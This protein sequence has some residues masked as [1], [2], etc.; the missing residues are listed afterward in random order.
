MLP[1]DIL[2][3]FPARAQP[4]ICGAR[5]DGYATYLSVT[6]RSPDRPEL[7]QSAPRFPDGVTG[8]SATQLGYLCKCT[9]GYVAASAISICWAILARCTSASPTPIAINARHQP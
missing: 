3:L 4:R 9:F 6:N 1:V 7:S 2:R 5:P 8:M